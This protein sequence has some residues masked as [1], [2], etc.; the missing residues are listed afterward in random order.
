M[1]PTSLKMPFRRHIKKTLKSDAQNEPKLI[2]KW[3]PKVEPNCPKRCLGVTSAQGWLPSSLQTPPRS[4]LEVFCDNLRTN[5][6]RFSN[7]CEVISRCSLAICCKHVPSKSYGLKQNPRQTQHQQPH[8]NQNQELRIH[9]SSKEQSACW[10][11]GRRQW[12]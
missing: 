11:R 4:I 3:G 2:P 12:V 6:D 9:V 5:L 10:K 7:T 8:S 1:D